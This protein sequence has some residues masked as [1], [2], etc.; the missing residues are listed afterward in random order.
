MTG[1]LG[2]RRNALSSALQESG[3]GNF[4]GVEEFQEVDSSDSI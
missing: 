1:D 2:E 3:H 4:C